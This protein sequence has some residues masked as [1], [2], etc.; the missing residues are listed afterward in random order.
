MSKTY[1]NTID[2]CRVRYVVFCEEKVWYAAG[3]E[4]NIVE[5]GDTPQEA[6]LLLFEAMTGYI[7]SARKMKVRPTVLN[8]KADPEYEQLWTKSEQKKAVRWPIFTFGEMNLPMA[9]PAMA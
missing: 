8:Q 5:S 1:S 9:A 4:F 2:K 7:E 6:L 3:L